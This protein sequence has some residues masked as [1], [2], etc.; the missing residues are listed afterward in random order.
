[1]KPVASRVLVAIFRFYRKA[2]SPLKP[3]S[4]RFY[5]SC[6]AYAIDAVERY[7]AVRGACMAAKRIVRCN[8]FH[9]GGFDP[10]L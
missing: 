10:V 3:R 2:L 7:G 6:S 8:P 9:P 1:M 4:C 5:P